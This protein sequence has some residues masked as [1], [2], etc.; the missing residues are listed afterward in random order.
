MRVS[1]RQ[2]FKSDGCSGGLSITWRFIT[3]HAPPFESCCCAHDY[4][5]WRGGTNLERQEADRILR[6]CVADIGYP[7]LAWVIWLAVR[8][9]GGS[10]FTFFGDHKW[11]WGIMTNVE[12]VLSA[13]NEANAEDT[14][15]GVCPSLLV[16]TIENVSVDIGDITGAEK[17]EAA[18]EWLSKHIKLRFLP[19][20][21]RR[22]IYGCIVDQIV[23]RIN[24]S[25]GKRW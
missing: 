15:T 1:D 20:W 13:I 10:H 7:V 3:G 22:R 24:K 12:K 21:M 14:M 16:H 2:P 18:I 4:L 9:F 17:R 19:K 23:E 11:G 5:Y 6:L 25:R 8:F